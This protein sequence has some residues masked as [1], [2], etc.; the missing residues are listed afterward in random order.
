MLL[1]ILYKNTVIL[2]YSVCLWC[3]T[4]SKCRP[5]YCMTSRFESKTSSL[6]KSLNCC[7]ATNTIP[8]VQQERRKWKRKDPTSR[9]VFHQLVLV[10][11]ALEVTRETV[12]K[13]EAWLVDWRSNWLASFLVSH[14]LLLNSV[15]LGESQ[16]CHLGLT[17]ASSWH[18]QLVHM[19]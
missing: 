6:L 11:T 8:A 14:R 1:A 9:L 17:G 19:A 7:Q 10:W 12:R 16:C 2:L 5:L 4:L 15:N 13:R 3:H 18:C